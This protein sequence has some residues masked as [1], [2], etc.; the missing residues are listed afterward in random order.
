LK[1]DTESVTKYWLAIGSPKNWQTAFDHGNL[2]G[3]KE[4]QRDL[5][6]HLERGDILLF[7]A[8][9]PVSGVI[10]Y[11]SVGNKLM[12]DAP[13]WPEEVSQDKVLWPFRVELAVE[14]CLPQDQWETRKSANPDL[15]RRARR[16]QMLQMI[17]QSASQEL[18]KGF[19]TFLPPT[20]DVR[21]EMASAAVT[22]DLHTRT[23][24][25]LVE[26]GRLQGFMAEKEYDMEG[27]RLDA[28]WRRVARAVPTY[29][30]EVHVSGELHRSLAKLK[31]AFD[32]WNSNIYLVSTAE[33]KGLAVRLLAGMFHEISARLN[34]I[35]ITKV[36]ELLAHKRSLHAL[37]EELGIY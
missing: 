17:E 35:E 13:L 36:E 8:G 15:I 14:Y 6:E 5:W 9:T 29:V 28:V 2:W 3:L 10:G 12:Q 25:M 4:N 33:Q 11:G 20:S 37:E 22:E 26:A 1:G 30:F 21:P 31:H 18:L 16:R 23:I 24:N 7:Y 32:I 27:N 34:F 19:P